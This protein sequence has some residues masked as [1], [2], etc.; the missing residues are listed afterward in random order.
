MFI[1]CIVFFLVKNVTSPTSFALNYM[2]QYKL[3]YIS[4]SKFSNVYR[5]CVYSI[6][7]QV[8]YFMRLLTAINDSVNV[9]PMLNIAF[10][11]ISNEMNSFYKY[12][13]IS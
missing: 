2:C 4:V 1:P 12:S 8:A 10:I 11:Y 3:N 5:A 7:M 6:H 13:F 9:S